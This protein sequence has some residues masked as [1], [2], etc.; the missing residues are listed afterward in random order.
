MSHDAQIQKSLLQPN[1]KLCLST[2]DNI[3]FAYCMLSDIVKAKTVRYVMIEGARLTVTLE[4]V[5]T[6]PFMSFW[7]WRHQNNVDLL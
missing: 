1:N 2:L 5:L 7:I 6:F 3:G 4:L